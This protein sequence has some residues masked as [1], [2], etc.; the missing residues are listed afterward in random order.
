MLRTLLI[1]VCV[2]GLL[3]VGLAVMGQPTARADFVVASDALRTVDP[4]KVS[5]LDEIQVASALFEGLTRPDPVTQQATPGVATAWQVSADG[6]EYRFQLRPEARWS[7]GD[8]VTAADF[9]FA[10]QRVLDPAVQSQYASLLF[11]LDAAAEY[12][13]SR[14]DDQADNDLPPEALGVRSAGPHELIVQ[15]AAPCPYFLDLTSFPTLAP[16]HRP[17]LERWAYRDGRVL[18]KTQH[19]WT[20][21]ANIVTN[22]AFTLD[23]WEFKRRLWLTASPHYWDRA[24]IGIDTLE[25]FICPDPAT[26]LIAYETGSIDLVRGLQPEVARTLRD[27]DRD[28]FHL[29]DRLATFF[30]R[31]NC[32]RPAMQSPL[33]RQALSLAIDKPMICQQVLGL[34]ETP[35]DT[36]V[37]RGAVAQMARPG[38]DGTPVLYAPPDGLG[39]G[40]PYAQRLVLARDLLA[41]SGYDLSRPIEL[42][43]AA[44]PALQRRVAEVVQSMWEEGLGLKVELL[45]QERTVLSQRIR[46]LDYDIVRS[47]WYGDYLDPATFLEMWRS[48]SGQ[49]RTGWKNA[50]YD[51]LID[52]AARELD[53]ARRFAI[54]REAESLLCREQLPI[55]PIYH[56]RGNYLLGP[57]WAGLHD[58]VRDVLPIH[59]AR[60]AAR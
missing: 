39:H 60:R 50:E 9:V 23:R 18:L 4:H 32:Q 30:F 49:N 57:G 5:W 17:T 47:D 1:I 3:L 37:P 38:P 53:P 43:F 25:L 27:S 26:A 11:V 28:D 59:R 19:L 20:R 6:R 36:F 35:A 46:Q 15:L 52:A 21:G 56:K 55:I 16:V 8:P 48:D 7:N 13:Q 41:R 29:G 33:L 2:P 44:D 42:A 54:F 14:L 31:I 22:G 40:L 58:N 12:Y 10:W 45:M 34:D 24:T 51:R